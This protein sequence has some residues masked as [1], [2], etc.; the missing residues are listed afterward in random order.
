MKEEINDHI[1]VESF[2][3]FIRMHQALLFPV[4]GIQNKLRITTLGIPAF[5]KLSK[6]RIEIRAGCTVPLRDLMILVRK[7]RLRTV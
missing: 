1:G 3:I 6:R 4:F 2:R 7:L 5:E